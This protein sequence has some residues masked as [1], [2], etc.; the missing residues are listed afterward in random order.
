MKEFF[1]STIFCDDIRQEVREK[2]SLMGCYNYGLIIN[3]PLP[4]TLNKFCAL[5]LYR[6]LDNVDPAYRVKFFM[7][8][9]D[10]PFYV[11]DWLGEIAE[12]VESNKFNM[13]DETIIFGTN[14]PIIFNDITFKK[15]GL[16]KVRIETKNGSEIKAG[17]LKILSQC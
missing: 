17:T 15:E 11:S 9:A 10:S 1:S 12:G 14:L 3:Q 2:Y 4:F 6:S 8:D 5:V 13:K 16:L 7:P